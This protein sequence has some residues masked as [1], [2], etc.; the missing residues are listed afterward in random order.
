MLS[1]DSI[2]FK[3]RE[4]CHGYY[5]TIS[6]IFSPLVLEATQTSELVI[7]HSLTSGIW[8]KTFEGAQRT[9]ARL[10]EKSTYLTFVIMVAKQNI[11]IDLKIIASV[12]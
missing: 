5:T 11:A 6:Q 9:H 1:L 3:S 2:H 10:L 8:Y 12:C 4:G 7:K